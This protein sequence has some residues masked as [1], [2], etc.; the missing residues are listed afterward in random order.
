ME[1]ELGLEALKSL[2]RETK[3]FD[4]DLLTR[5]FR[6]GSPDEREAVL[7]ALDFHCLP[8][9]GAVLRELFAGDCRDEERKEI[10][11]ILRRRCAWCRLKTYRPYLDRF[12]TGF[13]S[14]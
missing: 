9:S 2:G 4:G 3:Q 13:R 8:V 12:R 10:A 5:K 7:W 14:V 1:G 11:G 6:E